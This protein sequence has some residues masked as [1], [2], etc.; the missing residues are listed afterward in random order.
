MVT[1]SSAILPH[2]HSAI[3]VVSWSRKAAVVRPVL[4]LLICSS[5]PSYHS[6]PSISLGSVAKHLLK[7]M[8]RAGGAGPAGR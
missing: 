5:L 2:N 7:W 8:D 6:R 4:L 1:S 3:L